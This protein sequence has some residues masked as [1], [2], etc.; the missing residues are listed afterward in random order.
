MCALQ[1][2]SKLLGMSSIAVEAEQ[3]AGCY[4]T[5]VEAPTGL[6]LLIGPTLSA[7]LII[8][9]VTL[10]A[11]RQHTRSSRRSAGARCAWKPPPIWHIR[12]W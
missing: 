2:H 8:E 5:T 7:G 1:T 4:R 12:W 3:G 10:E 11:R 6:Q 9:A